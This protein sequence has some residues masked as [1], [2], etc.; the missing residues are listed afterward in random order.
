MTTE[1]I[2]IMSIYNCPHC[3]KKTFNP[4]SKA[5]A[6]QLNS[7]GKPC[8]ECGRL[9]V[10]GT[11]ATIFNAAYCIIAF[12]CVILVYLKAPVWYE[13]YQSGFLRQVA[14]VEILAEIILILSIIFVPRLVNAFFFKL[15][16]A[17]KKDFKL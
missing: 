5:F 6:G 8:K 9:C 16:P 7:H 1:R 3:G 10:N 12:I 2:S 4:I 14:E 17:I 13:N 15:E 11:A